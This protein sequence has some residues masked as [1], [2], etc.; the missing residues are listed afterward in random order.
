MQLKQLKTMDEVEAAVREALAMPTHPAKAAR[1]RARRL[2]DLFDMQAQ[3][4]REAG[5]TTD[6]NVPQVHRAAC[7]VA[8][9][10]FASRARQFAKEAS[11]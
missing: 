11:R 2:S 9:K 10:T 5:E 8:A 1:E 6:P 4:Y 7:F 3:L